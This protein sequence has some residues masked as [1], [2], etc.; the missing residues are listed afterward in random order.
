MDSLMKV[1]G[2][3][4]LWCG[5]MIYFAFSYGYVFYYTYNNFVTPVFHLSKLSM[6]QAVGL[7]LFTS[8]MKT[9][10]T[11]TEKE[12]TG[13][14]AARVIVTPWVVLL[15]IILIKVLFVDQL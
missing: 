6:A 9:A 13:T 11:S 12:D 3:I 5:A 8:L 2:G 7:Y 10:Q 1:L 14:V 15:T 4:T